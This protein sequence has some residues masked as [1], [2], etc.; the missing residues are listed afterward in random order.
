LTLECHC[1]YSGLSSRI[2]W[3][4]VAF[5]LEFHRVYSGISSRLLWNVIT[6]T[7]ECHRVHCGVSSL[8]LWTVIAY[9]LE[10]H[11]THSGMSLRIPVLLNKT[12]PDHMPSIC[13]AVLVTVIA[14]RS[15]KLKLLL[16]CHL[17]GPLQPAFYHPFFLP[18]LHHYQSIVPSQILLS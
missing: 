16:S 2:L 15:S 6:Y 13:N 7:L 8:M 1:V 9:T 4:V 5:T 18:S 14:V 12:L 17:F 3:S 11:R 10:C